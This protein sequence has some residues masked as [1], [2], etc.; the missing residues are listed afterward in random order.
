MLSPFH[1]AFPVNN[2]EI[3]RSFYIE[4]LGCTVG[5]EAERWIDFNFFG[6]QISAHLVDGMDDVATNP[7]D[8][9]AI[10]SRHFGLVLEWQAWHELVEQLNNKKVDYLIK[11]T[12]RFK[13]EV[14]EQATLFIQDP[15]GNALEFKSFKEPD[16]LFSR[17]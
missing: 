5:R 17:N 1:L 4:I 11:P 10:P 14:G 12:T 16:Q 9:E 13:G 7:V 6:H 8:G 15:S 3:T 2:I